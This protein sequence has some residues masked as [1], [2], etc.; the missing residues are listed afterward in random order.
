MWPLVESVWARADNR[1]GREG[2]GAK[3]GSGSQSGRKDGPQIGNQWVGCHA[4]SITARKMDALP[5]GP[6][7]VP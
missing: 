5:A 2:P 3:K 4:W 6:G 7:V 1:A